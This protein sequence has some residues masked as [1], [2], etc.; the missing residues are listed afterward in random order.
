MT[1]SIPLK[2]AVV[3]CGYWGPNLVRNFQSLPDCRVEQVCDLDPERLRHMR[4]LYPDLRTTTDFPTILENQEIRAVAIATPVRSHFPLARQCL[5]QGKHILIEKPMALSVDQCI[6]LNRLADDRG[7]T[8]MVGH[9]YLYSSVVNRIREIVR[10]GDLGEIFYIAS[11]RLNLGLFQQDINVA[12][13]LAPHDLSIILHVLGER[14]VA[15]NCQG[16]SHLTPGIQDVSTMWLEFSSG[17]V[18]TVHKIVG[19][20]PTRSDVSPLWAAAR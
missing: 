9:T 12:W 5:E 3:G 6:Q 7:L 1:H 13:D 8:L 19:W 10:S 2:V 16:K 17:A 20:I 15:V 4:Q 14:P 18:V 11:Q